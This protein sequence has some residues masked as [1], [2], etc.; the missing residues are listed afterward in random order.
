MVTQG[1]STIFVKFYMW[2]WTH[3][4]LLYYSLSI[5]IFLKCFTIKTYKL[6]I[7]NEIESGQ[8]SVGMSE[9]SCTS[10]TDFQEYQF[11]SQFVRI[12]LFSLVKIF[13]L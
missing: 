2:S 3:K 11:L 5:F 10:C 4:W 8:S 6:K 7:K 1:A 12:G 13:L 9:E